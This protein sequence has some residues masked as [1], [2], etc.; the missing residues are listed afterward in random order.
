MTLD[1]WTNIVDIM[2]PRDPSDDG[3]DE[4][5]RPE[6]KRDESVFIHKRLQRLAKELGVTQAELGRILDIKRQVLNPYFT[7][8]RGAGVQIIRRAAAKSGRTVA[9]MLGE[10]AGRA[11]IGTSDAQGNVI[12]TTTTRT[13][14]IDDAPG[15]A[16]PRGPPVTVVPCTIKDAA[17]FIRAHHRHHRPPTG[18]LFALGAERDGAL[19]GVAVVGRPVARALQDGRTAEVTRLATDG[20][21][22]ACSLLYAA[23]WRAARALGYQRLITYTLASEP[24]ASLRGAGWTLLGEA[25]GGSWS[26]PSRPREDEH[27]TQMKLLWE[28]RP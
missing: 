22:N 6:R 20:T 5:T 27:P 16:R 10:D 18:G 4:D 28:T 13:E 24:G 12:M 17:R 15:R 21:R 7:G 14:G 8:A 3:E 1:P 23:A 9:W 11:V 2:D 25:G 26:R 19:V